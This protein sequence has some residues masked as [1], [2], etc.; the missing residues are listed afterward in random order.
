MQWNVPH[1]SQSLRQTPEQIAVSKRSPGQAQTPTGLGLA[2]AKTARPDRRGRAVIR[3]P[4]VLRPPGITVKPKPSSQ[5]PC[6]RWPAGHK[7]E[8]TSR[9]TRRKPSLSLLL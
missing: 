5:A 3:Q 9:I 8:T 6:K 1:S 2:T 4:H 7:L